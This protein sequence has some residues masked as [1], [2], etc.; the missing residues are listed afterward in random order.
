M[1]NFN[2][3]RIMK[4]YILAGLAALA[5]LSA[6]TK[7]ENGA[8]VRE[9]AAGETVTFYLDSSESDADVNVKTTIG[10]NNKVLW[11]AGDKV[12]V[13]AQVCDVQFDENGRPF[14]VA[15]AADT[16][17]AFY[18]VWEG[19]RLSFNSETKT[20]TFIPP[21]DQ[22]YVPGATFADNVNPMI[23]E[24]VT[25]ALSKDNKLHFHH[26][27]GML[28]VTIKDGN[29]ALN[30]LKFVELYSNNGTTLNGN[31]EDVA[32]FTAS[33]NGETPEVSIPGWRGRNFVSVVMP[34]PTAVGDG[35]E[36]C[37]ILP[38]Q[39][40]AEGFTFQLLK[41]DGKAFCA[42]M[43]E[44][45]QTI[46]AGKTLAL[47]PIDLKDHYYS[48]AYDD[49]NEVKVATVTTTGLA[50]LT[51]EDIW[52]ITWAL[53][54]K[55]REGD[56]V[57]V[58]M[59]AAKYGV[60]E[61]RGLAMMRPNGFHDRCRSF[62]YRLDLPCNLNEIVGDGNVKDCKKMVRLTLPETLG[63]LDSATFGWCDMLTEIYALGHPSNLHDS[64]FA[65]LP[66][67]GTLYTYYP[68]E[69]EA[70][71]RSKFPEGWVFAQIPE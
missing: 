62:L 40:Y 69:Y 14:V 28:K 54:D 71:W 13:N 16:Y 66:A 5:V 67:K 55:Y 38:A 70:N 58:D 46:V 37:W 42:L 31:A 60:N 7:E 39:K 49:A 21:W 33:C 35:L 36:L 17:T 50:A 34:E 27:F 47:P 12:M 18:P 32:S 64:A 20:Y 51:D 57:F 29:R 15:D 23:A 8:A 9:P 2:L 52:N 6:C 1:V 22:N 61:N 68:A 53:K 10:E 65:G 25:S 11:S 41:D 30:N 59:K 63:W 45:D 26:I 56:K 44:K 3:I 4:R 24:V 19:N 43:T 48:I